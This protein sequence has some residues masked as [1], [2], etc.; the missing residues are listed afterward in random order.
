L[1][2]SN[3]TTDQKGTIAETSI[4]AAAV[5]IGI[6]V[7]KPIN[8]GLRYDLMFDLSSRLVRVQCKWAVRRVAVVVVP[9]R[10][11]RRTRD[12]Y[13]RCPYTA[14]ETDAI[15]AFCAEI[16]RCFLDS[17]RRSRRSTADH[18]SARSSSEQ[19]TT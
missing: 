12:G 13:L 9:L 19:P 5:R 10:S 1:P 6:G 11:C 4:I 8:D 7:L 17:D 14:D 3:M 15:A 2:L 18:A 16:N